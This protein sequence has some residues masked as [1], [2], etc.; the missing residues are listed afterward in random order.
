LA[1]ILMVNSQTPWQ[2]HRLPD[3]RSTLLFGSDLQ[4]MSD[5]SNTVTIY[6][7][8]RCSKSRQALSLLRE[9][10]I[11]PEILLYMSDPPSAE[12]LRRLIDTLGIEPRKLLRSKEKEYRSLGLDRPDTD[13]QRLIE[14]MAAHP[15]L[16]Q[17][18]IAIKAERAVIGRPPERVL[19]VL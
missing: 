6:H 7:N 12:E 4:I 1:R 19:D 2:N 18:P 15:R 11:E 9:R 8:P 14:A 16:I 13:P 10:G 5:T 17:R 3:V